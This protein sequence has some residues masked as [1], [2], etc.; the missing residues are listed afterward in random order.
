MEFYTVSAF[1]GLIIACLLFKERESTQDR[2]TEFC[3]VALTDL[4]LKG[5][6]NIP[7]TGIKGLYH[8]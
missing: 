8:A 3:Y 6:K 7:S 5:K 4:E 2:Q 1:Q